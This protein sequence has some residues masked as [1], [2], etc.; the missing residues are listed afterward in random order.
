MAKSKKRLKTRQKFVFGME[1]N[2]TTLLHTCFKII[3]MHTVCCC[4]LPVSRSSFLKKGTPVTYFCPALDPPLVRY[5]RNT[6]MHVRSHEHF[7][8]TKFLKHPLSGSVVKADYV[9]P[10]IHIH[11]LVHPPSFT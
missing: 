3:A 5:G 6:L 2:I 11:A 8:P 10:C 9:F 7:I 1:P 4:S